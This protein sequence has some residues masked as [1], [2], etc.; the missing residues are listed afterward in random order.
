MK[1]KKVH[2]EWVDSSSTRGWNYMPEFKDQ[3]LIVVSIGFLLKET[4]SDVTISTSYTPYGSAMDPL[5]IPRCSI[6]K[7]KVFK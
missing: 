4:K 5:T 3:E 7:L 2:I 1:Y 6:K